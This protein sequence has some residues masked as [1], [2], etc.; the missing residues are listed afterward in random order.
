M[1]LFQP[2]FSSCAQAG[3]EWNT[4]VEVEG[5]LPSADEGEKMRGRKFFLTRSWS[6]SASQQTWLFYREG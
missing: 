1:V 2:L 4:V 5:R 6:P 3:L